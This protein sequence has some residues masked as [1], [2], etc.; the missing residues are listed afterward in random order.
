[1]VV[2]LLF[3]ILFVLAPDFVLG[4]FVLA[5]YAGMI[6]LVIFI[7]LFGGIWAYHFLF[8]ITEKYPL[9]FVT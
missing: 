9:V 1:V 5:F 8:T 6:G 7:L 3:L 2:L 4:L